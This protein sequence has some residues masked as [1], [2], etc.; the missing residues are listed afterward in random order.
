MSNL[1]QIRILVVD[2]E[3]DLLIG[4]QRTIEMELD[5]QVLAA[6]GAREALDMINQQPVDVVLADIRMPGMDGM[7]LSRAI[8]QQDS[9]ITV[10]LMTAFGTIEQAVEAIKEGAYDYITKPFDK[11]LLIAAIKRAVEHRDL[12][13]D[14]VEMVVLDADLVGE[15]A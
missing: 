7:A 3:R 12:S 2:D 13:P 8:Q 5:C 1:T 10:I 4:L 6:G 14:D 9:L 11:D 15:A